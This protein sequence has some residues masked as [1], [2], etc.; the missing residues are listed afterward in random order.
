MI[1]SLGHKNQHDAF[2]CQ[3]PVHALVGDLITNTSS[4]AA[5]L[6]EM[7]PVYLHG[8]NM[9]IDKKKTPKRQPR[10]RPLNARERR[11]LKVY[12]LDSSAIQYTSFLPLHDLWNGYMNDLKD[13]GELPEQFAQKL[14]KADFHGSILTGKDE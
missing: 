2:F 10:N 1:L 11:S 6:Q 13:G 12:D 5:V 7:R 8:A 3:E 9:I 4:T 14:L